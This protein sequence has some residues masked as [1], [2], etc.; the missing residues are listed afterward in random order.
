MLEHSLALSR[1][2]LFPSRLLVPLA[3]AALFLLQAAFRF[4]SDLNHD[5]AWYL[6]VAAGLLDGKQLYREFIEVNPPL[7]IWLTV[8]VVGA[9]RLT[10]F[11][12]VQLTYVVF[13]VLTAAS[14]ALIARYLNQL[15]DLGPEKRHVL[16]IVIAALALFVP[17]RDFAQR[18]HL[19]L[20]FFLPWL[21][22]RIA[23]TAGIAVPPVEAAVAGIIAAIG[24]C[25]KP[26]SVIAPIFAEISVL[27]LT[28]NYRLVAAPENLAATGFVVFYLGLVG[29]AVPEFFSQTMKLGM[30]A[31]VPFYGLG[32]GTILQMSGQTALALALSLFLLPF[33]RKPWRR[34]AVMLLAA[35]AGLLASYYVQ[36]KG[37]R[38]QILPAQMLSY[39]AL[40]ATILG[41]SKLNDNKRNLGAVLAGLLVLSVG[42]YVL[43]A[44][45]L[46]PYQGQKFAAVISR[47]HPQAK[48]FFIASTHVSPGFPLAIG[49]NRIWASR[50]PAQWF[51]PYVAKHWQDGPLPADP[52]IA[53]ALDV[54]VSDLERYRPDIVFIDMR[55][56]QAYFAGRPLD[57]VKF[58]MNDPRFATIWRDYTKQ[59]LTG[60]YAIF[61]RKP[62]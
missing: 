44:K 61:V 48:S 22:L 24:I 19:L 7:G 37:F 27:F 10:G 52:I 42:P 57:Y 41:S 5:T 8:P 60:N 35:S 14:V 18:E 55:P 11:D 13:F 45:Q 62:D 33:I 6:H 17:A 25:L 12:A 4:Q 58:W 1:P 16:L 49:E 21:F 32:F 59:Q 29:I 2:V 40:A 47:Y 56:E 3:L 23:R 30:R 38:Y 46:Y 39:A 20:L 50:L 31:Y 15:T 51:A 34:V 36:A 54:T 26:H 53:Y 43:N 28:R 9:A